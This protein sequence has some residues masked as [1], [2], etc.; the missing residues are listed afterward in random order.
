MGVV[1]MSKRDFN[2]IDILAC[3]ESGR[4]TPPKD[5]AGDSPADGRRDAEANFRGEKRSNENHAS[6]NVRIR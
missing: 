6:T 2:R 4:L 5:G 1:Q 3:L